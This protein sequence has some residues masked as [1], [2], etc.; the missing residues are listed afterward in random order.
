MSPRTEL[1]YHQQASTSGLVV[2]EVPNPHNTS[3]MNG[4]LVSGLPAGPVSCLTSRFIGGILSIRYSNTESPSDLLFLGDQQVPGAPVPS[5]APA[6]QIPLPV[7]PRPSQKYCPPSALE[8]AN[9]DDTLR[10]PPLSSESIIS[11]PTLRT[12]ISSLDNLD[13]LI[14]TLNQELHH[15]P[16]YAQLHVQYRSDLHV[17]M[18]PSVPRSRAPSSGKTSQRTFMMVLSSSVSKRR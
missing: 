13:T 6:P 10:L 11:A 9:V 18:H 5:P 3:S 15:S 7:P 12:A 8:M 2:P 14:H 16:K 1:L 4:P 17:N